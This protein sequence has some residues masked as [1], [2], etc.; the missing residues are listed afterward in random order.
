MTD[1]HCFISYSNADAADFATKLSDELEGGHPFTSV[2]FDK[3]DLK[4]GDNWD[5]Q[6]ASAIR[7][8]K[9][10]VFV[11]TE[12]STSEGSVCK[13]EWTWALKYKK[14]VI[15]IRLHTKGE[16]PFRLGSRQ[17]I[18]FVSN[19]EAGIAKL[20]RHFTYLDSAEGQLDELKHRLADAQRDLRRAKDEDQSRIKTEI[21]ELTS[22][23]ENQKE[24]V[25]NPRVAERKTDISISKG[26]DEERKATKAV[27]TSGN[28]KVINIASVFV[29]SYFQGRVEETKN[30]ANFLKDDTHALMTIVGRGGIG[31]SALVYRFLQHLEK[32][33]LPD[34]LG[35]LQV[36]GII[37]LRETGG[38][39]I[40]FSTLYNNLTQLLPSQKAAE[41]DAILKT[42]KQST[43]SKMYNLLNLFDEGHYVILLDNF[44]ELVDVETQSIRNVDLDIAL[45]TLL[46]HPSHSIKIIITTR[47]APHNLNVFQPGRQQI[48]HLDQGLPSP[49]AEN[50]LRELDSNGDLG[51]KSAPI[52]LLNQ[53]REITLGYPRALEALF[54]ILAADRYTGLGELLSMPLPKDVVTALVGEGF[55][56]LDATAQ[57][58]IQGLA[59]FNRPIPCGAIDYLL[60]P[61]ISGVNSKPILERLVSMHF[62]KRVTDRYYLHPSDQKY[63]FELIPLSTMVARKK[64]VDLNK[65]KYW[66]R[67]FLL[68][69]A[70]DYFLQIRKPSTEWKS[71]EDLSANL[72]EYE[73]RIATEDYDKAAQAI[74][75]ATEND[76]L[77][78]WGYYRLI[79]DLQEPL[80]GK[81]KDAVNN[82]GHK[83]SLGAAYRSLGLIK[84]A[85]TQ[86]EEI[87]NIRGATIRT[88]AIAL[89]FTH[90]A[91]C[92][93]ELGNY[94][95]AIIHLNKALFLSQKIKDQRNEAVIL[96]N[97]SNAHI[98]LGDTNKS[99]QFEEQALAIA[100]RIKI[101]SLEEAA[102][103]NFGYVYNVLGDTHKAMNF[104]EQALA[105]A[106]EIG[107]RGG[108]STNLG[109]I[110]YAHVNMSE[111]QKA[112]EAFQQAIQIADRISRPITQ[113]SARC[114]L[115]KAYLFQNDLVNARATI[116]A[117][118]QYNVP[119]NNHN[120][121][122]LHGVIA[123]RQGERGTAQEAFTKS[124]AQADEILAKTPDYYDALDAKGLAICGLILA[125]RGD[126]SMPIGANDGKTVP[127]DKSTVSDGRAPYGHD[128]AP[129]VEDAIAT[130]RKARKIAP[131]AGV[132]KSVLRL[133]DE[134]VKCEG[135]E[136]L[137]DV[138]NAVEGV[139]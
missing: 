52:D 109:V 128:I 103:Q 70:A 134:L 100:R 64:D 86:F 126:P 93:M 137:K 4:P 2:W 94:H 77:L 85:I 78:L 113:Q 57:K 111:Y 18:D 135:G 131:H 50:L 107:Y 120:V 29:P 80:I 32:G 5:D 91:N 55:N 116:E 63:T 26:I 138:R 106:R 71:L 38:H 124:I 119:T 21:E 36:N 72:I 98:S 136:I 104:L 118:L 37:Y 101:R 74:N 83:S 61:M 121:T 13:D 88:N 96:L 112:K 99:M 110:G 56:R 87:P 51:L 130:F 133:F 90:L 1:G 62:A 23:I 65:V 42:A 122:A 11:L 14:P 8:C 117:A 114:G 17:F 67:K 39:E 102:L 127:P 31:K 89:T 92:Y 44:D 24:I 132:V 97:L 105:I 7:G 47:N 46:T 84:Q 129:T 125:G 45:H 54:G 20:R 28:T 53:A 68:R 58:V 35:N 81:L 59:I 108:E 27:T 79:I 12:D 60:Q 76:Y 34:A 75:E 30:I 16:L 25:K 33:L 19:F 3:R 49:Y 95:P 6:I 48:K 43:E 139:E 15:P 82:V 69:R 73:Y 40:S 9:C 115:S 10:L 66:N 41:A 123:L 22:Q